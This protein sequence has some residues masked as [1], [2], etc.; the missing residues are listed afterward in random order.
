MENGFPPFSPTVYK[1]C[2]VFPTF[3][4]NFHTKLTNQDDLTNCFFL[5]CHLFQEITHNQQKDQEYPIFIADI[6]LSQ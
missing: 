4:H 1:S 2:Y 5:F 3:T 6:S